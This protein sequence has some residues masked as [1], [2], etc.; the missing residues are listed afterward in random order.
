ML[1]TLS[2]VALLALG[3]VGANWG[4]HALNFAQSHEG[5]DDAFIDSHIVN[6]ASRVAGPI[7]RLYVQDNQ[8]V[9]QGDPIADVDPSDFQTQVDHARAE[10]A[11]ANKR[12]HSAQIKVSV[13]RQTSSADVQQ[14]SSGVGAAASNA[15]EFESAVTTAETEVDTA[16]AHVDQ[17]REQVNV[18][19][20]LADQA[21]AEVEAAQAGA[22][23]THSDMLRAQTLFGESAVSQQDVDH[24]TNAWRTANAQLEAARKRQASQAAAVQDAQSALQ[25]AVHQVAQYQSQVGEAHAKVLS[26]RAQVGQAQG[27]LNQAQAAPQQVA[28]TESDVEAA[29]ADVKAAKSAVRQAELNLSYTRIRASQDGR[30]TRRA[31]EPGS[32]VQVG[33]PLLA[34]V[35]PNVWVTANFK[36]TQLD[37]MHAGQPVDINVDAYPGHVFHG[38]ID[39]FQTGSGA[40]FSL[41]PPENATGNYV[42]VVQRI[43]VKIVF[44]QLP[45]GPYVL[46]PGMSVDPEVDIQ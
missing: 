8:L 39:S 22:D 37:R 46:G 43:P 3:S 30:V 2:L 36:E 28:L 31:I 20:R 25:A 26:A 41:L 29:A 45:S 27:R 42:K 4:Y 5:T 44:D 18:A 12:W 14:A 16:H 10:L 6:V 11:A 1:R 23:N 34:L 17:A 32:Y 40:A 38:H 33:Q 15:D 35:S 13:T 21:Q 9:H 19:R 7:V 24:A